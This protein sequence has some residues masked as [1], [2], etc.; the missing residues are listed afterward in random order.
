[1][2]GQPWTHPTGE[3]VPKE[4]AECSSGTASDGGRLTFSLCGAIERLGQGQGLRGSALP[5]VG[6]KLGVPLS[7]PLPAVPGSSVS[8]GAVQS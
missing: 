5:G 1:M 4:P 8:P 7:R 6:E 3:V 2:L